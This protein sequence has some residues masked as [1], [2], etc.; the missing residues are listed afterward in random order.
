MNE[1]LRGN[2]FIVAAPS[3]GG[4]TS[5]VSQL[6]NRVENLV[7]SISHTTRDQRSGEIDGEHYFFIDEKQFTSMV[8][9]GLF[10]EHA[11]VFDHYYGTS[12]AEIDARLRRGVDVILD[13]D[14]QG[15]A[16]IKQFFKQ[17]VSIFILPPSLDILEQRLINRQRDNAEIIQ[18]RMQRA[19]AEMSHYEEFDY[20][21]VN[22][23]FEKAFAELSSIITSYRLKTE[24]QACSLRKL[25]SLL[26]TSQ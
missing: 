16:Q 7:V 20:L 17:A 2:L 13:I 26:L 3:G 18:E 23:N 19:H 5:L 14:W 22:D 24:R 15:A 4:K 10:V 25:L 12:H 8:D 1:Q 21:I 11:R 9:K 6:V